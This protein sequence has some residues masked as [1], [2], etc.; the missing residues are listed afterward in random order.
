M[1]DN[2]NTDVYELIQDNRIAGG[3][4]KGSACEY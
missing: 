3:L 4:N 2:R 1:N